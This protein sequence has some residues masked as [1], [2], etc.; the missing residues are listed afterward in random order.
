ML[1]GPLSKPRQTLMEIFPADIVRRR[2]MASGG[3]T[4]EVVRATSR[5]KIELRFRAPLHFLALY[6]QGARRKLAFVPA[7]PEYPDWQEPKMPL[8]AVGFFFEPRPEPH[9]AETE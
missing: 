1:W 6:E 3:T 2:V 5:A 7:G 8:R 4:A 9:P